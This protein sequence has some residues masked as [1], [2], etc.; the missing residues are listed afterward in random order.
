LVWANGILVSAAIGIFV[1]LVSPWHPQHRATEF[2]EY[3]GNAHTVSRSSRLAHVTAGQC[4]HFAKTDVGDPFWPPA[5]KRSATD[6][7]E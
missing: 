5:A 1:Q 6:H 7:E 4:R 2:L 3:D